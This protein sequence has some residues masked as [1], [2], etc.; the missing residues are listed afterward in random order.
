MSI[1]GRVVVE[2][3]ESTEGMRPAISPGVWFP[4]QTA[5]IPS[6]D[7]A[8]TRP[9]NDNSVHMA[10]P[11]QCTTSSHPHPHPRPRTCSLSRTTLLL[12][13]HLLNLSLSLT[14]VLRYTLLFTVHYVHIPLSS[15]FTFS[16]LP[17]SISHD[18]QTM[19]RHLPN[20]SFH[21]VTFNEEID[22]YRDSFSLFFTQPHTLIESIAKK[23]LLPFMLW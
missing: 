6:R 22:C 19:Y 21:Y 7:D 15:S 11:K 16:I 18:I 14:S 13:L 5:I 9:Y 4:I 23:Y 12:L 1:Y 17:V 10:A 3:G 2:V 8:Y 20:I